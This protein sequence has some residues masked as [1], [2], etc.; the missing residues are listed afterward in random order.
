MQK[1]LCISVHMWLK[2]NCVFK[3]LILIWFCEGSSLFCI[4]LPI[5]CIK[6]PETN[7]SKMSNL[8]HRFCCLTTI[9]YFRSFHLMVHLYYEKYQYEWHLKTYFSIEAYVSQSSSYPRSWSSLMGFQI[10]YFFTMT[11]STNH[12]YCFVYHCWYQKNCMTFCILA[13]ILLLV[14]FFITNF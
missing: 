6:I 8:P 13:S 12:C 4:T 11:W 14:S 1:W 2:T 10:I 3:R 5:D 7:F 9:Y